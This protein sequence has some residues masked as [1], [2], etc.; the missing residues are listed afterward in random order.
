MYFVSFSSCSNPDPNHRLYCYFF[1]NKRLTSRF[2]II[3]MFSKPNNAAYV[4]K[5]SKEATKMHVFSKLRNSIRDSM[6][7]TIGD[8]HVDPTERCTQC[9]SR[10]RLSDFTNLNPGTHISMAGHHLVTHIGDKQVAMYSHH[11]IVKDV[12]VIT[13]AT[14]AVTM[15]RFYSTP[16]DLDLKILKTTEVLDLHYHEIY[17]IQYRHGAFDAQTIIERAEGFVE[18]AKDVTY[19]VFNCNCEHFCN[20][21]CVGNESSFQVKELSAKLND[22]LGGVSNIAI[23]VLKV[24]C[25]LISVSMDDWS[26]V[27]AGS[28]FYVPW[29]VLSGITIVF[30]LYTIY[31]HIQLSKQVNEGDI[32]SSCCL[33]MR[34]DMWCRFAV[35]CAM[36]TGGLALLFLVMGMGAS[37]G[38]VIGVISLLAVLTLSIT[39]SVR[40]L[41]HLICSPFGG[42]RV[43]IEDLSELSIGDVISFD[44]W[45]LQH[46]GIVSEIDNQSLQNHGTITVIHY[47]LPKL[48][49]T[50]QIVEEKITVDI[51]K[52][53]IVRHDY[54]GYKTYEPHEV[55]ERARKRLGETKFSILGNR[56]CH[57]VFWAKVLEANFNNIA[58][59]VV[60]GWKSA[61]IFFCRSIDQTEP[62]RDF[63]KVDID[64]TRN[65]KHSTKTLGSSVARIRDDVMEGQIVEFK[66]CGFRHKAVSTKVVYD[67]DIVSKLHLTVVHYSGE[68]TVMEETFQFD[69][70]Y[71][72]IWVHAVH[73]INRFG[74]EDVI[75]RASAR[76]GQTH[77]NVFNHRSSH[78]A[79][80]VVMKQKDELAVEINDIK[81]GDVVTI[82]YWS[83]T[84]DAVVSDVIPSDSKANDKG[85]IVIV[86]YALDH[87]FATHT[88][89]EE[90][91]PVDLKQDRIYIKS[92]TGYATYPPDKV[93]SRAMSRKREKRYNVFW[94]SS[95]H[96]AFWSKVIQRPSIASSG[97]NQMSETDGVGEVLLIPKVGKVVQG[98]RKVEAHAWDD[99]KLG[100]I[101]E[102]SYYWRWHQGIVS[103]VDRM[104]KTVKVIHYGARH[105][106]APRTI[107][108]DTLKIDLRKDTIS[109]YIADPTKA[110]TSMEI[111]ERARARLGESDWRGG[112]RSWDFCVSCVRKPPTTD[113]IDT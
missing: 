13:R 27:A 80:E 111:L 58:D 55:V 24:V 3:K 44:Y 33:R 86:H 75:Q 45:R 9:M 77:Y 98:F 113:D 110:Y 34:Q 6:T 105:I 17:M 104:E 53:H 72:N 31:Q 48:F 63:P 57:L 88:V 61:G 69:L 41:R 39:C 12:K 5:Q 16:F 37:T 25:R 8:S 112:N 10:E 15:I 92:F 85:D 43:E 68:K 49:G 89:K 94:N 70:R 65:R 38:F 7:T 4:L 107:M 79:R 84:H 103:A 82:R 52:D 47:S 56:S 100:I 18:E 2:P 36:Q 60:G 83:L 42:K 87:P 91:F 23:K 21:C 1:R 106:V 66:Y 20:W 99:F 90:Q 22:L 35:F 76:V 108:E 101:I 64:H 109:V 102:F 28:L 54:S 40:K 78:L 93:I 29:G 71:E 51:Q 11:A 14:A 26:K 73:P 62:L 97:H 46:D 67:T 59:P 50:R 81:P 74:K 32:C 30:L 95:N 19:S 96:F